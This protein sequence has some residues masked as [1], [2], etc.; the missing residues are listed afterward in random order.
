MSHLSD[1]LAKTWL[2]GLW[3]LAGVVLGLRHLEMPLPPHSAHDGFLLVP[4]LV[5]LLDGGTP[6]EA[7]FGMFHPTWFSPHAISTGSLGWTA[8]AERLLG[9]VQSHTWIDVP[10]PLALMALATVFLGGGTWPPVVIQWLYLGL[11]VFSLYSI[12]AR[13]HSREAGLMAGVL[14]LGA[15]AI[16]GA[17]QYIEPHLALAAVSTAVVA[18]LIHTEGLARPGVAVVASLTLWSLSR[19]GEGSGDAVIAGLVVVGPVVMSIAASDRRLAVGRWVL[20]LS[21]L[22]VPLVLLADIPWMVAA[23]E[24]ITR[25]FADPAVQTDVVEKGGVL[26]HPVVWSGAYLVLLV[27]DYLRPLLAL[28]VGIGVWGLRGAKIRHRWTLV[29]WGV[30]PWLALSVMQRKAAWYGIVLVPPVLL[31]S[32]IGLSNLDRVGLKRGAVGVAIAQLCL[33]SFWP[34]TASEGL[35]SVLREPMPLHA[36]RLRRIDLLQPMDTASNRRLVDDLDRLVAWSRQHPGPIALM[37]MGAKH[38]YATRYYLSMRLGGESVINLGDPRVRAARYRSL[39]PADFSAFVFLDDGAEAWPPDT[40]QRVWLSEDLRCTQDDPF[41]V[42]MAGVM[43]RSSARLGGFYPLSGSDSTP[44]GPG[45]FWSGPSSSGG[46]C[47]D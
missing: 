5:Q 6:D 2:I 11:L 33:L 17:A 15:P 44:L 4:Q 9:N 27:T 16:L 3:V 20:G 25:A 35:L 40:A 1:R 37:T 12:G 43:S 10:H 19:S 24:R 42:F 14:A 30:V 31:F 8:F 23:M 36:W 38:D 29:L 28:V 46:L 41:D 34:A 45:Q 26:S 7:R 21:A 32:A 47:G 39:H 18:L 13:A 22:V